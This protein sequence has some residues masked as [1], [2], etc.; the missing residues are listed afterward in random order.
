MIGPIPLS[1]PSWSPPSDDKISLTK[2]KI[3]SSFNL[4]LDLLHFFIRDVRK[5][6]T[7]EVC[8]FVVTVSDLP[9]VRTTFLDSLSFLLCLTPRITL[10]SVSPSGVWW[11]LSECLWPFP[12]VVVRFSFRFGNLSKLVSSLYYTNPKKFLVR[13]RTYL[14]STSLWSVLR[15]RRQ[16]LFLPITKNTH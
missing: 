1:L 3:P 13:P 10:Y 7:L 14:L 4:S 15:W 12:E 6:P 2:P 11:S 9:F 5:P 16:F 8:P